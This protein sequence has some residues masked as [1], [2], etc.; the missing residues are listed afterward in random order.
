MQIINKAKGPRIMPDGTETVPGA[1]ASV[2]DE[3][4]EKWKVGN[5]VVQGWLKSG[6]IEEVAG[7]V[8]VAPIVAADAAKSGIVAAVSAASK[9]PAAKT[10]EAKPEPKPDEKPKAATKKANA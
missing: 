2:A 5:K 3:L 8:V 1:I 10:A 4:W 6:A 7:S 9:P